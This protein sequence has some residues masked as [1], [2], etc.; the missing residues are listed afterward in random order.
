MVISEW[1]LSIPYVWF[2]SRC[3][4]R[5]SIL[6]IPDI[7]FLSSSYI[8]IWLLCITSVWFLCI[9]NIRISSLSI[10]D[11]GFLSIYRSSVYGWWSKVICRRRPKL[12]CRWWSMIISSR[13]PM[14]ISE[15]TLSIPY[16]W[17]LKR[18]PM[19]I[20]S[21]LWTLTIISKRRLNVPDIR[22]L[23]VPRI[24]ICSRCSVWIGKRWLC[25]CW[26]SICSLSR[27]GIL[28]VC[29]SLTLINYIYC[30]SK[31]TIT[32]YLFKQNTDYI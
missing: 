14:V 29:W 19:L 9:S 1:T 3:N 8:R 16:V 23:L 17:F 24:S 21:R 32:V 30:S 5:I 18:W 2:L 15:W 12:I 13:W 4:I 27:F 6:S 31:R 11:I 22:F 25:V 7:R 10:S 28:S 20:S 26:S